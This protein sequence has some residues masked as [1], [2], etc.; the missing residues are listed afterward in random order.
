MN[1][2]TK[3]IKRID[4]YILHESSDKN[5]LRFDVGTSCLEPSKKISKAIK[6]LSTAGLSEYPDPTYKELKEGIAKKYDINIENITVTAGADEAISLIPRALLEP[7]SSAVVAVP[8][9]YRI[10]ESNQQF[11]IKNMLVSIAKNFEIDTDYL[12][13]IL[14]AAKRAKSK[15]IY[16]CNPNNPTGEIIKLDGLEYLLKK[17]GKIFVTVDEAFCDFADPNTKY[18]SARLVKKYKNLIVIGSLSK[19]YGLPGLRVGYIIS[20]KDIIDNID[21]IKPVFNVSY[22]S[23]RIAI[24]TLNDQD[25]LLKTYKLISKEREYVIS[26]IKKMKSLQI[27]GESCVNIFL[28]RHKTKDLFEELQKKGIVAADFRKSLGLE[29]MGCVRITI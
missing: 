5:C 13:S 25:H 23:N 3:K 20:N 8:T 1:S 12:D 28:I 24:E 29:N 26:N 18:S 9:F 19:A 6:N 27:L 4:N 22:L 17:A 15:M 10:I 2:F 21:V 11:G 16:V 14:D 7:K